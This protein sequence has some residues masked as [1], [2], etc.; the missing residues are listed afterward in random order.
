MEL[1]AVR[2][3]DLKIH[4]SAERDIFKLIFAFHHINYASHNQPRPHL[5][6]IR[7][8]RKS[9]PGPLQTRD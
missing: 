7:R 6:A 9:G 4:F 8:R 3:V 1:S 5:F 2:E